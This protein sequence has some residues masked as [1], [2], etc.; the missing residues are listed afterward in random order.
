MQKFDVLTGHFDTTVLKN[1]VTWER[2]TPW[3]QLGCTP[4]IGSQE[5]GSGSW[6]T[7]GNCV[8]RFLLSLFVGDLTMIFSKSIDQDR[9]ILENACKNEIGSKVVDTTNLCNSET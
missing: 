2:E 9:A 8:S 6:G 1:T 5:G 7:S 4:D 3:R